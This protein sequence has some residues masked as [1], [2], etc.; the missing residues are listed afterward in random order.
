MS[1]NNHK[2][3]IVDRWGH[4]LFYF[5]CETNSIEIKALSRRGGEQSTKGELY[6]INLEC[7]LST[8]KEN[9]MTQSPVNVFVASRMELVQ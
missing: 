9:E 7:L 8:S 5:N 4:T 6:T 2:L 3:R 1:Q